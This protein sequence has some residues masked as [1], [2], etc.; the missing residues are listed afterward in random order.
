AGLCA[1]LEDVAVTAAGLCA[2]LEDVAVT[3]AGL[4]ALLEDVAVTAA[5]LCALLE[6][7]A[8]TPAGL[9]ALL[10]DIAVAEL[11]LEPIA[12]CGRGR[13]RGL[14][15]CCGACRAYAAREGRGQAR[16]ADDAGNSLPNAC[17]H[18]GFLAFESGFALACISQR[19]VP[20]ITAA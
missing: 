12:D 6:D 17:H 5:G 10:E 14:G 18:G 3:A 20:G 2:L 1:L 9:S 13:W 19:G 7:V 15:R 4:C 11:W 16:R 8:A